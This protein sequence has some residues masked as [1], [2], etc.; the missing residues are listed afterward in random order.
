MKAQ[1]RVEPRGGQR[2]CMVRLSLLLGS[3]I[4]LVGADAAIA[5]EIDEIVVQARKRQESLQNIPLSGS[6]LDQQTIEDVGGIIDTDQLAEFITGLQSNDGV[7][8]NTSDNQEFFIRGAGSGRIAQTDAAT[9][10]LRNGANT[11]GGFGGRA[12]KAIDTF[13]VQQ[14][15]VYRGAQGSLYGRSAVGGVVNVVNIAP[16]DEFEYRGLA[17]YDFVR[18]QLRSEAIVNYPLTSTLYFRAGVQFLTEDGTYDNVVPSLGID[19]PGRPVDRIGG[20]LALRWLASVDTDLTLFIDYESEERNGLTQANFI[21]KDGGTGV[22]FPIL[23][24]SDPFVRNQDTAGSR[25]ENTIN[26]NLTI[27]HDLDF[28]TLQSITNFRNRTFDQISDADGVFIGVPSTTGITGMGALANGTCEDPATELVNTQCVNVTE[29]EATTFT[30]EFRLVGAGVGPLQWLVGTDYRFLYNPILGKMLGRNNTVLADNQIG[31]ADLEDTSLGLF[32]SLGY[33]ILDGLTLALAG[34]YSYES[35]DFTQT[36]TSDDPPIIFAMMTIAPTPGVIQDETETALFQAFSPSVT[37]SYEWDEYLAYVSWAQAFRPGGFN[38]ASGGTAGTFQESVPLPFQEEEANS[39]EVGLKG[40]S[41][42]FGPVD[43]S[44]AAYRIQYNNVLQN[45][46]A[47][48]SDA[49]TGGTQVAAVVLNVG[50]AWAHG[51]EADF[52]GRIRDIFDSGGILIYSGGL[53]WNESKVTSVN[54]FADPDREDLQLQNLPRWTWQGNF[55]YRRPMPLLE[56]TG[57]TLFA[58]TNFAWQVGGVQGSGAGLDTRKVWN[59]RLGVAGE[60]Y[61]QNW[62]LTAFMNNIFDVRYEARRNPINL[63]AQGNFPSQPQFVNDP[64]TFGL[65]LTF[66]GGE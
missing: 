64:T 7:T 37:L 44:L 25:D 4:A 14:I 21:K 6:V 49:G 24:N 13:D 22:D 9:V 23:S 29:S 18:D 54:S 62:Q 10:Q 41:Q 46:L 32:G 27:N 48:D 20:R 66:S 43:W 2:R 45:G 63:G 17:S 65:R 11:A 31:D 47:V 28:A 55:T 8:G 19:E 5:Q 60:N 40:T 12:F 36:A 34:R 33:E 1:F 16:K 51:I 15:E 42:F 52:R 39:F 53:T 56:N 61:G 59:A 35:R 58:N 50:D 57:L 30:Q 3:A 38:F 26:V